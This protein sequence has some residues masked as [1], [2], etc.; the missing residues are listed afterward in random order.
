MV[1]MQPSHTKDQFSQKR[2][3]PTHGQSNIKF[4]LRNTHRV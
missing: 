4:K 2:L 3:F 1:Q